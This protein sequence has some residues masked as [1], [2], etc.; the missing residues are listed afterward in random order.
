[1]EAVLCEANGN[2][3]AK[4]ALQ[5]VPRFMIDGQLR[6]IIE[7][8]AFLSQAPGNIDILAAIV[9]TGIE[10]AD[11]E[12]GFFSEGGIAAGDKRNSILCSP[13]VCIKPNGPARWM[14]H[15]S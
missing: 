6:N 10:T 8:K 7:E 4:I 15:A 5:S 11:F 13:D 14:T 3:P 2:I 9:E 12:Q 1:M